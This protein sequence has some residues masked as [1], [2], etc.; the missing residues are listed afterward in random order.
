MTLSKVLGPELLLLRAT[1]CAVPGFGVS[2]ACPP[3]TLL[4]RDLHIT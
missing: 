3:Q 1:P 4:G 2:Q